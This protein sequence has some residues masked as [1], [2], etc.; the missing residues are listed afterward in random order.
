ML[1]YNSKSSL[2]TLFAKYA[3]CTV[4]QIIVIQYGDLSL[5]ISIS[6]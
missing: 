2:V 4:H 3:R 1:E 5:R 6:R